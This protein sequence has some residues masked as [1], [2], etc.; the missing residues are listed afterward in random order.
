MEEMIASGIIMSLL[1]VSFLSAEGVFIFI[2]L[3]MPSYQISVSINDWCES[4]FTYAVP[5]FHITN[6]IDDFSQLSEVHPLIFYST[7]RVTHNL[8]A[9]FISI[10]AFSEAFLIILRISFI[11]PSLRLLICENLIWLFVILIISFCIVIKV[12][13]FSRKVE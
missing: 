5:L 3:T 1:A 10:A 6:A 12:M 11:I 2:M 8:Y 7:T 13:C 9:N 4:Y